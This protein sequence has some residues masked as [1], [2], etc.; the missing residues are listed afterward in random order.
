L[1]IG[2]VN[3]QLRLFL[4][5]LAGLVGGLVF[6]AL[7]RNVAWLDGEIGAAFW[8]LICFVLA[9]YLAHRLLPS[10][11][12]IPPV[13][14]WVVECEGG[15]VSCAVPGGKTEQVPWS[16]LQRVEVVTTDAGPW[17]E[18]VF[19]LLHGSTGGC[20][21]PQ[22]ASGHK[23]L[24]ERLQALPGFDNEAVIRA[25]GSTSNA[26]FEVWNKRAT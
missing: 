2:G 6:W 23:R 3:S 20:A 4:I 13:S 24:L 8:S 25:M 14:S 10:A 18:D 26:R 5:G 9:G 15:V 12:R 17:S 22:G 16:D 1:T 11:A 7:S 21:V 19:W